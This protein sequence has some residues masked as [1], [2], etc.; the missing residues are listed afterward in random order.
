MAEF[1]RFLQTSGIQELTIVGHSEGGIKAAN[2]AAIL[3]QNNPQIKIN[4][5]VLIGSMGMDKRNL[6]S[7]GK[8]FFIDEPRI[9]KEELRKIGVPPAEGGI[10]LLTGLWHDIKSFGLRYPK[11]FLQEAKA[12]ASVNPRLKEIKAPVLVLAS[13]RD[14]VSDYRRFIPEEE[15][16]KR[17]GEIMSDNQ[18]RAWVIEKNK[19][20]HLPPVEQNKF[21]SKDEFINHYMSAYRKQEEKVRLS[22]ARNQALKENTLPQAEKTGFTI[23]TRAGS[24]TGP[25]NVREEQI[26]SVI[27]GIFPRLRRAA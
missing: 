17:L 1:V 18:L 16:N 9:T 2:L 25:L 23:V 6:F 20:E 11:E 12:M 26:A 3:E 21:G 19:W 4:G 14:F 24:H 8:S 13:E 10:Q 22:N 15:V 5:V 7:L 27:S